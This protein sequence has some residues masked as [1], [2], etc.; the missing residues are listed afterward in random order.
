MTGRGSSVYLSELNLNGSVHMRNSHGLTDKS[1]RGRVIGLWKTGENS[2]I[3]NPKIFR[4]NEAMI[5]ESA[6]SEKEHLIGD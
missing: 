5:F 6:L 3:L 2:F 4:F 1:S